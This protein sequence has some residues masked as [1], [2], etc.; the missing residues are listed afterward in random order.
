MADAALQNYWEGEPALK[1]VSRKV[2]RNQ[3]LDCKAVVFSPGLV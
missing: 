1:E 2:V 3:I